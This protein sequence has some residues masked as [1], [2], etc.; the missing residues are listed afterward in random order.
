MIRASFSSKERCIIWMWPVTWCQKR[1][2]AHYSSC[3]LPGSAERVEGSVWIVPL[4][5]KKVLSLKQVATGRRAM[6]GAPHRALGKFF[7]IWNKTTTTTKNTHGKKPK[8]EMLWSSW[9]VLFGFGR[10]KKILKMWLRGKLVWAWFVRNMGL[11]P[12]S[13]HWERGQ[14][15]RHIDHL[16]SALCS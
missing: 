15:C 12:G 13:W 9:C 6:S 3:G 5:K 7:S 11:W 4:K 14:E 8:P 1:N 16:A 2:F 10:V